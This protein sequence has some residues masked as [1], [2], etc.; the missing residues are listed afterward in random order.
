MNYNPNEALARIDNDH[1]L[2]CMLIDVFLKE[3]QGYI[4]RLQNACN[5]QDLGQLGDAAHNVK[6]ASAAIGLEDCRA[7]A[8]SLEV[9]CRQSGVKSISSFENA[10]AGLMAALN[11]CETH[12]TAWKNK[13]RGG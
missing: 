4:T 11:E 6:G 8:E 7:L 12:L 13:N 10:T 1:A 5:K 3:R 9:A 2:L